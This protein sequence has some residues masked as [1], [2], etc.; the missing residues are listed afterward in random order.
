MQIDSHHHFWQYNP[1]EY[2]WISATMTA[3][4]RDFLPADLYAEISAVGIDGVVSVQARQTIKETRWLLEL[5]RQHEFIKGVVGWMPLIA[6]DVEFELERWSGNTKLKAVRHV[7]H[8]EPDDGYM[9]R[10]DFNRGI[11]KL[12]KFNLAYDLLIFQRHLPQTI[13]FVDQHAGQIFVLDHIAKPRIKDRMMSPWD[14]GI[15]DLA[16]R[17]NVYCKISGVVTESDHAHWAAADIIP[18]FNVVLDAFGPRRLMFGSDWPVCLLASGYG[19]WVQTIR[20]F[21]APLSVTQRDQIMGGTAME[22]YRL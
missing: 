16:R 15:K 18:Y 6:D 17:E 8:D 14:K 22:A 11:E 19:R 20:D 4:K 13:Q 9:L 3:L 21:I 5:A 12:R 7:L 10:E 1:R 2:A